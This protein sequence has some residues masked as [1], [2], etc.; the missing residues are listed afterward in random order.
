[1]SDILLYIAVLLI[2]IFIGII[3]TTKEKELAADK[4][5]DYRKALE[6]ETE[7]DFDYGLKT[8]VGNVFAHDIVRAKFPLYTGFAEGPLLAYRIDTE[9]YR[10]DGKNSSWDVIKSEK[11]HADEIEFMG[12]SF[13]YNKIKL[14]SPEYIWTE[15]ISEKEREKYYILPDNQE[16]SIYTCLKDGTISNCSRFFRDLNAEEAKEQAIAEESRKGMTFLIFWIIA[17][18]TIELMIYVW[19][20]PLF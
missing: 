8:S 12:K 15:K 17:A 6:I 16:G 14:P 19:R 2:I 7:E 13:E 9:R 3:T 4:R 10:T 11:F 20:N 1:M 18:V 5:A